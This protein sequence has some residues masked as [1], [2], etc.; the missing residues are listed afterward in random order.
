[1]NHPSR[2]A[3]GIVWKVVVNGKDAQ[4][5]FDQ[6][7]PLG[8][9]KQKFVV[10]FNRA[11][12]KKYTP[13]VSMGVRYPY[14]QT[15]IAEQ[16]SWSA[17]STKY[18]VYG[19]V[20]LNTG[21]G[22]NTIRVTGAKDMDHFDI[23][24]EDRRFR[25]VVNAAGSASAEFQATAGLGKVNLEWNNTKLADGLGFNMYRMELKN[26]TELTKP[27][28][29]NSTLIADTLYT[30]FAVTPNKKYYYYYKILR[31]NLAETDSSK[32]V[33]TTPFTASKGD[34]NGDLTVNV[35]DITTI[36]AY[37]LNNNP[38]PFIFEAA[39]AN[40]DGKINVLDIVG[41]VN[42]VLHPKSAMI[43]TTGQVHLYMQND[44]LF[45]DAPVAVGGIQW[46]I[47]G[48]SSVEEII[49]LKALEG[50]E[51]GY[52]VKDNSLRLLFY[53]LSGKT[54]PAGKRIPLLKM[55]KGTG[56]TNIIFGDRTGTALQ[57]DYLAT[58]VWN[59]SENLGQQVA[60]L[61]QNFPNPL[62]EQTTIPLRIFEPVD[63]AVV[64]IVNMY[65]QEVKI[66]RLENPT[67]GEHLLYWKPGFS[68]GLMAY[69]L[70]IRRG[71]K[72]FVCAVRKMVVQ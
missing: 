54:V 70:E 68:K 48:V 27:V 3:H 6:L 62:N 34:A 8:V 28:L 15:A 45:A 49:R 61:G 19:T 57:V 38:Q 16:G 60:E 22:I 66:F 65:G 71:A 17:D 59:L 64:R 7:D 23:P 10:Y 24:I 58:G 40:S 35:L 43:P 32:V 41:V 13:T 53:S 55:K 4:D 39:D 30:D 1:M 14:S 29:I 20:G 47:S 44:T 51:S 42:L 2:K 36:V 37:L 69:T 72:R 50:F 31:T 18:T 46:D 25:V 21:D 5:E 26:A 12:D 33:S 67:V 11:M 56:I 9:A 52:S 63:E